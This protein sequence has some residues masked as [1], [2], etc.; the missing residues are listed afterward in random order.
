MTG[1]RR[2]QDLR[3]AAWSARE[4]AEILQAWDDRR[5]HEDDLAD[6][7]EYD[8]PVAAEF[9]RRGLAETE[10]VDALDALWAA[11]GLARA[12]TARQRELVDAA[13]LAGADWPEI[14]DVLGCSAAEAR[15][16]FLR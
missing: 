16:R 3:G 2:R 13:R 1:A 12:A 9:A 6:A 11:V 15:D 8:N 4:L 10:P 7:E 5:V 14:A